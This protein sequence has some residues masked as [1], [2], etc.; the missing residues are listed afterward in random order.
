MMTGVVSSDREVLLRIVVR[1]PNGREQ[2]VD[3]VVDTGFN[4]YLTLP[5]SVV[6]ALGLVYHSQT[7]AMLADGSTVPLRRHEGTVDWHAQAR[8]V[9]VL[10]ADGGPLVGMSLLYGSRM[11]LDVVEGG[12]VIIEPTPRE[13]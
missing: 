8:D 11:T 6:A 10:E 3:A 2:G 1:G 7:V 12:V 9:M 5:H 4:G 13:T